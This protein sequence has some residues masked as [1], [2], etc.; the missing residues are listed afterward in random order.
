MRE[1]TVLVVDDDTDIL[2]IERTLLVGEGFSILESDSL[3]DAL[4]VIETRGPDVV[5][6][7]LV[8]PEDPEFGKHAVSAIKAQ[9]PDQPVF[10]VTSLNREYLTGVDAADSPFDEIVTKPVDVSLL[11]ALIRRYAGR[12]PG[13]ASTDGGASRRPNA[14]T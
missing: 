5:L 1:I 3:D 12:R 13:G 6:L 11:S 7:D 9:F 8:F 4:S 2:E 10:L 14:N